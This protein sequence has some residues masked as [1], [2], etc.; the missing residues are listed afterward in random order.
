MDAVGTS[1]VSFGRIA[2]LGVL[3]GSIALLVLFGYKIAAP[4]SGSQLA[5]GGR[6]NTLGSPQNFKPRPAPAFTLTTFDSKEMSLES[7]RG[8]VVVINFWASWCP[9]CK[10]EAPVLERGWRKYQD[11]G[12]VVLGVDTWDDEGDARA[13]LE[14]HGITYPNGTSEEPL[15]TEYGIMGLPETFVIDAEGVVIRRW[16][17]PVTDAQLAELV[18]AGLASRRAHARPSESA[19]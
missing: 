9:P 11:E 16:I 1:R 14:E 2:A 3:L 6:V 12:V 17:G 5:G 10:D 7:L 19:P 8:K 15:A 13:F 4:G 18:E